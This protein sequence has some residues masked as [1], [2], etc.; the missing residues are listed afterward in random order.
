[1]DFDP[2]LMFRCNLPELKVEIIFKGRRDFIIVCRSCCMIMYL[3]FIIHLLFSFSHRTIHV[4]LLH[5]CSLFR[6]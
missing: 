1:M 6:F 4:V 3:Y 2:S 5:N